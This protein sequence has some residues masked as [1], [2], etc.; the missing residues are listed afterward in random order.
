MS[1]IVSFDCGMLWSELSW[2][3]QVAVARVHHPVEISIMMKLPD[4]Q[5]SIVRGLII[6]EPIGTKLKKQDFV[7]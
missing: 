6:G 1:G 5:I 2:C 4:G 7:F 3:V